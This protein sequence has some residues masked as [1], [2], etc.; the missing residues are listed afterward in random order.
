MD[1]K[2]QYVTCPSCH[3]KTLVKGVS[4]MDDFKKVGEKYVCAFCGSDIEDQTQTKR[5]K[6]VK[7]H[8]KS[9]AENFA[10][11]LGG[12]EREKVNSLKAESGEKD[13]CKD[14]VHYIKHPFLSRCDYYD[15]DVNPMDDC[16]NFEPKNSENDKDRD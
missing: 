11:L 8:K 5:I 1:E 9:P 6:K 3:K 7:H 14:C 12:D 10:K 16:E 15:K 13:F 4:I 2:K